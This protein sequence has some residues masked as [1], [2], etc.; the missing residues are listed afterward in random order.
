MPIGKRA[1]AEFFATFWLV[2]CGNW[3][4]VLAAGF[5]TFGIG[6]VSFDVHA[7][8]ASNGYAET[9]PGHYSLGAG[10]AVKV[11]LT[12]FFLIIIMGA[13]DGR[14]PKGFA[15]PRDRLDVLGRTA[16]RRCLGWRPLPRSVRSNTPK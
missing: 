1:V 7:G 10:F 8:F 9:S 14:A 16:D 15:T 4:A 2:F 13:S 12:A 6:A 11:V 3:S 5:P